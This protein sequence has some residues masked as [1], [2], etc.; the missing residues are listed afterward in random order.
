VTK[1]TSTGS[2]TEIG[3]GELSVAGNSLSLSFPVSFDLFGNKYSI[4]DFMRYKSGILSRS[5]TVSAYDGSTMKTDISI[6]PTRRKTLSNIYVIEPQILLRIETSKDGNNIGT[7]VIIDPKRSPTKKERDDLQTIISNIDNTQMSRFV[8]SFPLFDSLG[9]INPKSIL[10]NPRIP[11]GII[12]NRKGFQNISQL[13]ELE[14]PEISMEAS[15]VDK[16]LSGAAC[17]GSGIVTVGSAAGGPLGWL[18][19]A[20]RA[21]GTAKTCYDAY[22]KIFVKDN[23]PSI[24]VKDKKVQATQC[25]TD[26]YPDY[27][28][29]SNTFVCK[30]SRTGKPPPG[31]CPEGTSWKIITEFGVSQWKCVPVDMCKDGEI[32]DFVLQKCVPKPP[33]KPKLTNEKTRWIQAVLSVAGG[34]S[35][36]AIDGFYGR[37]TQAA[38]DRFQVRNGLPR[39]PLIN[40]ANTTALI[41][42]ALNHFAKADN[43]SVQLPINGSMTTQTINE[44]KFYQSSRGLLSD[45]SIGPISREIMVK[46]LLSTQSMVSPRVR[47]MPSRIRRIR[48]LSSKTAK[49]F[50]TEG[51]Y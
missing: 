26:Y 34:E 4:S 31:E 13:S 47:R 50:L 5:Y 12:L 36:L 22:N 2:F 18:L 9:P 6:Q 11:F 30:E 24:F 35:Q 27:D 7:S 19:T 14:S 43:R 32:W 33:P 51:W 23:E 49:E 37:Q 45:G 39:H 44:I 38:L 28:K 17:L 10:I 21:A 3:E 20:G 25:P 16:V 46:E 40:V 48:K 29:A 42:L 15:T 41:Q 8:T 1:F